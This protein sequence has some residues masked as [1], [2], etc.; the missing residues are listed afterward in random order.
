MKIVIK[1]GNNSLFDNFTLKNNTR[2]PTHK[3]NF[4]LN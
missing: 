2:V 4:Y 1:K 3:P